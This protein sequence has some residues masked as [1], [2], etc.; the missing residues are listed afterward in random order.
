M[1]RTARLAL[2]LPLLVAAASLLHAQTNA[3]WTR[4]FPP[5]RIVGNIYW[6][7]S[8][9]LSTYLITTP[10]G[11]ILINTGVGDTAQEIR[12]SVE[13]LGFRMADT[14]II[15]ATHG[16]Y[17]HVAGIAALK[18]MTGARVLIAEPDKALLETGGKADFRFGDTPGAQF[19]P[20]RVDGT[21]RDGESISIGG[22]TLVAHLHAGHTR[23]ATS[24]TTTVQDG[25]R[26]YRVIIANMGSINPG[27]VLSGKPSYPTI[28]QDYARTFLAQKDLKVDV[29]LASHASQFKLHEKFKPGDTYN[30]DRF[31]DPQ[32]YLAEV[33]RLE[34]IY[35]DQLAR[36]RAG[37]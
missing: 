5:F 23:G 11:N 36:E 17:D 32:G 3:E 2:A 27:V 18:R 28:A 16:H 22:T 4:P 12:K 29:F 9:D 20:A 35:L 33:Q 7:G 13:Q 1:I 19:E 10:Q 37:R 15:T 8:Y 24:F 14:K 21:F 25:G 30:P 26:S 31:V 6:V 34:T